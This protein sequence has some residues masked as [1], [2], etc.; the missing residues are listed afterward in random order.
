MFKEFLDQ[1]RTKQNAEVFEVV[2]NE[3]QIAYMDGFLRENH[4]AELPDDYRQFLSHCDGFYY[5]GLEAFG[6]KEH[7]VNGKNFTFPNII[8]L[9][10]DKLEDK[11]YAGFTIVASAPQAYLLC[12]ENENN[13]HL[14]TP[15]YQ[16][17][18]IYEKFSHFIADF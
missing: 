3:A 15:S 18:K 5:N 7:I 8:A 1:I 9:N 13:Y 16:L 12:C 2:T 17:I 11:F 10:E 14:I 6:V 4:F